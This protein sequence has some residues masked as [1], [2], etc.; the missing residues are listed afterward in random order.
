MKFL[1]WSSH[2]PN[3]PS[4]K[5][6][7]QLI[8]HWTQT[9]ITTTTTTTIT[10]TIIPSNLIWAWHNS[11]PACL[12]FSLNIKILDSTSPAPPR[13]Q[14]K[15]DKLRGHFSFKWEIVKWKWII[16]LSA[17]FQCLIKDLSPR[18][19]SSRTYV[20]PW[21]D[22]LLGEVAWSIKSYLNCLDALSL[23]H[24]L[25]VLMIFTPM[26]VT[27][28]PRFRTKLAGLLFGPSQ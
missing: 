11:A 25:W 12:T 3:H 24:L 5:V 13:H 20:D 22:K 9:S 18:S 26:K 17:V 6:R 19:R 27:L 21:E 16:D 14:L 10:T 7:N 15:L 28:H 23:Y 4:D 2:Q 8:C 1:N